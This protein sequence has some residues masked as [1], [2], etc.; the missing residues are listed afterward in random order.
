M[1]PEAAWAML[2]P[3]A[4]SHR[5]LAEG[6]SPPHPHGRG[7]TR[8]SGFPDV[9]KCVRLWSRLPPQRFLEAV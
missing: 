2:C 6:R 3:A 7:K 4:G 1:E 5:K 8:A 9:G